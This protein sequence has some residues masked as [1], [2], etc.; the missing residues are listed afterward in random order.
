MWRLANS[1]PAFV[2]LS[3]LLSWVFFPSH[4]WP[5]TLLFGWGIISLAGAVATV[6]P[7]PVLPFQPEQ[8]LRH[9]AVHAVYAASQLPVLWLMWKPLVL[10]DEDA[11][12]G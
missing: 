2:W 3:L 12:S 8:S 7:L 9:Y 6:L 5:S 11:R 4:W 10:K 1:G